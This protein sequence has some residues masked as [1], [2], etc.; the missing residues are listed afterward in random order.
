MSAAADTRRRIEGPVPPTRLR[1]AENV[2]RLRRERG[3]A[4][5]TLAA[6]SKVD[7]AELAE[8]LRGERRVF[9]DVI[10]LLSGALA[11]EADAL[12]EGIEWNP[13]AK[14]GSGWTITGGGQHE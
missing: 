13:P 11:V 9:L 8:L 6:R 7:P 4:P 1:F 3:Y 14:G 2:E 10:Y 12:F 5:D